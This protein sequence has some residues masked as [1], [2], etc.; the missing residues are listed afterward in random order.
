MGLLSRLWTK[1]CFFFKPTY[2]VFPSIQAALDA[3]PARGGTLLLSTGTYSGGILV[4]DKPLRI[5]GATKDD[6][7][8]P[9][10]EVPAGGT[11]FTFGLA[12]RARIELK[13][14]AIHG[15]TPVGVPASPRL[16]AYLELESTVNR[17]DV[18]GS[19]AADRLRDTMD[20]L[21]LELTDAE[22]TS[23]DGRGLQNC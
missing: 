13:D 14:L 23:L 11:A 1:I 16:M 20:T 7:G 10:I 8:K 21:Y 4:P 6:A 19:P 5:I 15:S 18:A 22:R 9:I 17:L 2:R 3:L 12:A